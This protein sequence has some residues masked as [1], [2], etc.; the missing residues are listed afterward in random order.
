MTLKR[1]EKK[2]LMPHW[3]DNESTLEKVK[4]LQ[5]KTGA[6]YTDVMRKVVKDGLKANADW[7]KHQ[8]RSPRRMDRVQERERQAVKWFSA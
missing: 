6:N 1:R 7:H 5:D 3:R 2:V 4:S 8:Y